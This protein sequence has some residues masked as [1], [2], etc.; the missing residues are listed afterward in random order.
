MLVLRW[1]E[2]NIGKKKKISANAQ[3]DST[4]HNNVSTEKHFSF[5][6]LSSVSFYRETHQYSDMIEQLVT[7][8]SDKSKQIILR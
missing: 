4:G 1:T 7:E 2:H 3:T 8:V 5:A 6:L